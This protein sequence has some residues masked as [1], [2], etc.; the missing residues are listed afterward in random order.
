[1]VRPS[2][3]VSPVENSGCRIINWSEQLVAALKAY[4][5]ANHTAST[6]YG[7]NIPEN[8]EYLSNVGG[9]YSS[10]ILAKN[11]KIKF[12]TSNELTIVGRDNSTIVAGLTGG[13]N[14]DNNVRIWAGT[15]ESDVNNAPFRVY[16]DGSLVATKAD[17]KGNIIASNENIYLGDQYEGPQWLT[18]I[19]Q[20][21]MDVIAIKALNSSPY[22]AA[23]RVGSNSLE[24]KVA[25]D[26]AHDGSGQLAGGN[27]KWDK[28]GNFKI[29][30][31]VSSQGSYP[32]CVEI[33]SHNGAL[34]IQSSLGSSN[35][36]L[37]GARVDIDSTGFVYTASG[38][39]E[40][41]VDLF[42]IQGTH[43]NGIPTLQRSYGISVVGQ[44]TANSVPKTYSGY[45]GTINISGTTLYFV[46]GLFI[47]TSDTGQAVHTKKWNPDNS[48]WED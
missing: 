43:Y 21:S 17:I 4:V 16:E 26:F 37:R 32:N 7:I 9:I 38:T 45:T 12:Q 20:A 44:L 31:I 23:F 24:P 48:I 35:P 41:D 10:F 22:S 30:E 6:H 2:V 1:M 46:N 19:D 42:H 47:G 33:D 13:G 14:S 34:S 39:A 15:T 3:V 27:I 40:S 8:F 25:N 28:Y 29:G 36:G 18:D 5:E 11:A